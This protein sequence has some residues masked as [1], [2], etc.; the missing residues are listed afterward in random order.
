[1][2]VTADTAQPATWP[3]ASPTP[4]ITTAPEDSAQ[5]IAQHLGFANTIPDARS[6]SIHD[7]I[8]RVLRCGA[9]GFACG[10]RDVALRCRHRF[11]TEELH[12]RVHADPGV[13]ELG[14]VGVPEAV[15]EGTAHRLGVC[16]GASERAPHAR[17]DER[18]RVLAGLGR[19][20]NGIGL[21]T[22]SSAVYR[23]SHNTFQVD[24]H[25]LIDAD[26]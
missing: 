17:L 26:S 11:V 14:R 24:Q 1:V 12:Q 3:I 22:M 25:R 7:R 16:S 20:T 19:P 4:S 9:P 8:E 6:A 13:G 15:Y 21:A 23:K 5:L 10:A 18:G 2:G